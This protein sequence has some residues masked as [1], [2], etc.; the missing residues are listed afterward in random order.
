MAFHLGRCLILYLCFNSI[1]AHNCRCIVWRLWIH[2][3]FLLVFRLFCAYGVP[4][5]LGRSIYVVLVFGCLWV[6]SSLMRWCVNIFLRFGV[7]RVNS[8]GRIHIF[9][10]LCLFKF[11]LHQ[12][13][14]DQ[15]LVQSKRV[16]KET[17]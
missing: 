6:E 2:F 15:L 3:H 4:I 10:A 14:K 5:L 17:G 9:Y 12:F 16:L 11:A 1:S 13:I 8:V 7:K